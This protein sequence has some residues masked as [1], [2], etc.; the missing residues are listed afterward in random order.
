MKSIQINRYGGNDVIEVNDA[1]SVP[2][3]SSGKI[4]VNVKSCGV[5][6]VDWKIREGYM[7][8][9]IQLQFPS[10]LGL[11]FSGIIKQVGED[12][13]SD[14]KQGDEVYGQASILRGGSGAFAESAVVDQ[15]AIAHKP[16]TLN[17]EEAAALPLVG[18]SAWQALV[19]NIGLSKGQK[20]L[21]HGGAGGIGSIAIQL[22]K[23][24]GAYAK[25]NAEMRYLYDRR[26]LLLEGVI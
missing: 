3:P 2:N 23:H 20:I 25:F 1:T 8:Q 26:A 18:V 5:N 21:I 22:A 14:F 12:V 24:L 13:P 10:T 9:M 4:L 7:K 11:D 19:E 17:H 6:P 16:K 15:D